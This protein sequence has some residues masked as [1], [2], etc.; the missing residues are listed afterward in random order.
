M[1][2]ARRAG[3]F[4]AVTALLLAGC[5]TDDADDEGEDGE[6]EESGP[7]ASPTF[8]RVAVDGFE[9]VVGEVELHDVHGDD[10]GWLAVGAAT[11][12]GQ[13]PQT[14]ALTSADGEEFRAL[15]LPAP[16][17]PAHRASAATRL[18]EAAVVVGTAT[19]DDETH[20]VVWTEADDGWE[21]AQ[22]EEELGSW[23]GLA[24]NNA[25][26][27]GD[28]AVVVGTLLDE[29]GA[30][31][32]AAWT[33]TADGTVAEADVEVEDGYLRDVA[34][35][36][37]DLLAVGGSDDGGAYVL[38]SEDRGESWDL[39]E[40]DGLGGA[41]V[42]VVEAD[43]GGWI[44]G[45]SVPGESG[46]E[47]AIFSSADGESWEL[48]NDPERSGQSTVRA[49]HRLDGRLVALGTWL[50]VEED[51]D[52]EDEGLNIFGDEGDGWTEP[53]WP[54]PGERGWFGVGAEH[55]GRVVVVGGVGDGVT[56]LRTATSPD[57]WERLE[58]ADQL[59]RR[60]DGLLSRWIVSLASD[61]E[62]LVGAGG[63]LVLR[64]DV[65]RRGIFAGLAPAFEPA[66]EPVRG[67][68][69]LLSLAHHDE[70]GFVAAGS[71][72]SDDF[73]HAGAMALVSADG[74]SWAE[75]E[76]AETGDDDRAQVVL[77]LD[78]R[79]LVAGMTWDDDIPVSYLWELEDDE[80]QLLE[81]PALEG[82]GVVD[83]CA[84]GELVALV[85]FPGGET[86]LLAVSQDGGE[87]FDLVGEDPLTAAGD[88]ACAANDVGE[89]LIVA[90]GG[91]GAG[92]YHLDADG[93]FEQVTVELGDDAAVAGVSHLPEVGWVV[94]A[95]AVEDDERHGR[96]HVSR[97]LESW[98]TGRLET[99]ADATGLRDAA[100]ADGRLH[101]LGSEDDEMAMWELD[102]VELAGPEESD[103]DESD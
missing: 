23:A 7:E 101:L 92:L 15:E 95:T 45:G 91:T 48:L 47:A 78:G 55:D 22:L 19:E 13:E 34:G 43:D 11:E 37:D 65:A 80:L 41:E 98:T 69:Q 61:G 54:G 88:L 27:V 21:V 20:L 86:R 46:G 10:G 84:G 44:A 81:T 30:R 4:L 40:T 1:R 82:F 35:T 93:T 9:G 53:Q 66:D 26:A 85:V 8:S 3:A 74:V 29:D 58:V 28:R 18:D 52:E 57:E 39:V 16:E 90:Q 79:V 32:P 14:A 17:A 24:V 2:A 89:L 36:D 77:P 76:V 62:V 83:G 97:D 94:L 75:V 33:V 71:V 68:G 64:D 25:T 67:R 51:E 103:T 63:Q 49:V 60:T 100:I 6:V 87:S 42:H 73:D 99:D 31:T 5:D 96:V 70:Q 72:A 59:L 102:L 50:H 56:S 38:R 12:P